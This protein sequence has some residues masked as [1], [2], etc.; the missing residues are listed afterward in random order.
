MDMV[1]VNGK[2]AKAGGA[3]AK[4]TGNNVDHFCLQLEPFDE[5]V[6]KLFLQAKGVE[7]GKFQERYGPPGMR[8]SLSLK[9]IVSNNLELR[10][11]V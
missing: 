10:A 9:D 11:T 7:A 2:L 1:A 3:A 4:S 8:L 5:K 6:L